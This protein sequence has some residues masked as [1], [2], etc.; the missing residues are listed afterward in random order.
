MYKKIC[1][2]CMAAMDADQKVCPNCGALME[3][4]NPDGALPEGLL[5]NDT[6]RIGAFLSIDGEGGLY[7]ALDIVSRRMYHIKE[8]MPITLCSGRDA[9]LSL[10]VRVGSEVPYKNNA[11]DFTDL[12]GRLR[13]FNNDICLVGVREVFYANNTVYAVTEKPEGI[14]LTQYLAKNGGRLGWEEALDLLDPLWLAVERLHRAGI[15][16]RG[17][18]CDNITVT[19]PGVVRLGGYATQAMRSQGTELKAQLYAGF[20]APEQY[21]VSAF[22]GTFTD[23]YAL[24][25]V[26]YQ[27]VTGVPVPSARERI[28]EDTL[29]DPTVYANG[30]LPDGSVQRLPLYLA[31]A[32]LH[33][34]QLEG[35]AR[36]PDMTAFR[37]ALAGTPVAKT[38]AVPKVAG[39]RSAAHGAVHTEPE[40]K[41]LWARMNTDV[42]VGVCTGAFLLLVFFIVML[43]WFN[44]RSVPQ[45]DSGSS[46]TSSSLSDTSASDTFENSSPSEEQA[47][48]APLLVGM[49]YSDARL[50]YPQ[51]R[52]S[53]TYEYSTTY[54]AGV[55]MRQTPE[56]GQSLSDS[57]VAIVVSQG[58]EP[59][60]L[61]DL[62]GYTQG[63]AESML[64]SLGIQYTIVTVI[65]DGSWA[66]GV[67]TE[68]DPGEGTML[69]PGIDT[70]TVRISSAKPAD[71]SSSSSSVPSSSQESSSSEESSSSSENTSSTEGD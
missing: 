53:V 9:E 47:S 22:D 46:D 16:H 32:I 57:T 24:S 68:T 55:I 23:V 12:Y 44:G 52:F 56:N 20:A 7:E 65:N 34:L 27:T 38:A 11:T 3:N 1:A 59:V 26:L 61:P 10:Q 35:I 60:P 14:S 19:G 31:D 15:V 17:I 45:D 49:K 62:V 36:F 54:A 33:G 70:V 2:A 25:A 18:C 63:S 43:V 29:E 40:K 28:H 42:K 4:R 51:Y 58:T 66:T 69:Q 6:Y 67:V 30:P 5:L 64:Q 37:S 13:H 41:S 48:L 39:P 71:P 8:Y 50:E 21:T